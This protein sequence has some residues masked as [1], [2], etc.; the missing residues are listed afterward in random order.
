MRYRL[1]T[2]LKRN[3]IEY[4]GRMA[5]ASPATGSYNEHVEELQSCMEKLFAPVPALRKKQNG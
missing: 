4:I 2:L 1:A 3:D 5:S